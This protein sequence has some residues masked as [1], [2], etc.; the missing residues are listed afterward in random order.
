MQVPTAGH[1]AVVTD[2]DFRGSSYLYT[3]MTSTGV[4]LLSL[5]PSHQ[6]YD[7]GASVGVQFDL[8]D[9]TVYRRE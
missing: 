5:M 1:R 4:A 7:I 2:R 3:L 6:H 9:L 8:Q